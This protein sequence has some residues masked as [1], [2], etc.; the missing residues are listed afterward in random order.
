MTEMQ[1]CEG[2]NEICGFW[3]ESVSW[4][5]GILPSED[6]PVGPPGGE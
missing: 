5:D 3:N 4:E 6:G 2:G 1:C